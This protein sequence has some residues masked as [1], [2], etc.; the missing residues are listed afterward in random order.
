MKEVSAHQKVTAK[1]TAIITAMAKSVYFAD[2]AYFHDKAMEWREAYEHICDQEAFDLLQDELEKLF[3]GTYPVD[4]ISSGH[5][6]G[7]GY[8]ISIIDNENL[9]ISTK[10]KIISKGKEYDIIGVERMAKLLSN[11]VPS[12]HVGLIIREPITAKKV[13]IKL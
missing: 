3:N 11:V 8:Y 9:P 7:R 1:D 13:S 6:L 4:I 2:G 10:S 12:R 5:I